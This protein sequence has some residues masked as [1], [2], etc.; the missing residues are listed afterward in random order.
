LGKKVFLWSFAAT[1]AINTVLTFKHK[2]L[3]SFDVLWRTGTE[4]YIAPWVR[5][6][7]YFVGSLCGWYLNENRKSFAVSNVMAD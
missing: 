1:F 5:I 6:S 4:L 7:P 2:F 3:P